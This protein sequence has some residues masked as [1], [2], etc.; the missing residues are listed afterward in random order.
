MSEG[1][2]MSISIILADDHQMTREGLRSLLEE[3]SD[4]KVVA[5]AETG[6]QTL[7]LTRQ[8]NPDVVVL[9]IVMP[10]LNGM[11]TA[12][13]ITSEFPDVKVIG[14]SMHSERQFVVGMLKSGASGYL[15]KNC[16]F[17]ELAEAIRK[18]HQGGTYITPAISDV[19]VKEVQKPLQNGVGSL[20][21]R[22]TS[23]EREV[24]QLIA[25]AKTSKEIAAFLFLSEK[26]V[27]S[28]RKKIMEKL[29]AK[30]SSELTRIAI[31]EGISPLE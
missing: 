25:E 6:N 8:F 1:S 4:M 7:K 18:V 9:D 11:E 22:L 5:E 26:T 14:L 27:H 31:K 28:H 16:A 30:N 15:L 12:L 24:L 3:L 2:D 10:D 13:R 29:N 19:V 20:T 23:R 21:S 17:Q